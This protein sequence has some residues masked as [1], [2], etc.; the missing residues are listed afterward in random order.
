MKNI[1]YETRR[2]FKVSFQIL[3]G[4]EPVDEE[5]TRQENIDFLFQ[6]T[7]ARKV[8]CEKQYDTCYSTFQNH[9][10]AKQVAYELLTN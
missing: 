5:K 4:Y 7:I 1:N 3:T 10:R 9:D 2:F 6:R 8:D